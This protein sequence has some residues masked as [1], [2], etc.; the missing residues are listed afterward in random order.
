MEHHP[1]HARPKQNGGN[2]YHKPSDKAHRVGPPNV[3][4]FPAQITVSAATVAVH[5]HLFALR[6]CRLKTAPR[7]NALPDLVGKLRDVD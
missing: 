5:I 1:R 7:P 4:E 6:W 2:Q 3:R